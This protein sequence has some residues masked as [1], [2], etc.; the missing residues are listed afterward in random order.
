M[1]NITDKTVIGVLEKVDFPKFGVKGLTAKMDTGA[2]TGALHCTKVHEEKKGSKNYL[3]FSPFDHPEVEI[4][5]SKFYR[6]NIRSSN[7][8]LENRYIIKTVVRLRGKSY[9]IVLS[10]TDRSTMRRPVIIG[11]RFFKKY[12]MLVDASIKTK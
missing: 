2:Y 5:T 4:K 1:A 7:G 8:H 12:G 9:P 11:R 10:L 6:R 3:Y